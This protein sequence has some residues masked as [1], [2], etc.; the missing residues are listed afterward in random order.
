MPQI[1]WDELE[2]HDCLVRQKVCVD[3]VRSVLAKQL[4]LMLMPQ[5]MLLPGHPLALFRMN[6]PV[7]H[8]AKML[9]ERNHTCP[10]VLTASVQQ[11]DLGCEWIPKVFSNLRGQIDSCN[12][13]AKLTAAT[14]RSLPCRIASSHL[15]SA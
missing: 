2:E 3:Q 6:V 14:D 13:G 7:H 8:M 1:A 5:L 15:M 9:A 4:M 10:P 11:P 12:R